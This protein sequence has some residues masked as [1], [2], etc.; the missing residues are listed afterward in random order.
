MTASGIVRLARG[1]RGRAAGSVGLAALVLACATAPASEQAAPQTAAMVLSEVR[2]AQD[3][4]TT[5]VGLYGP[6][7]AAFEDFRQDQPARIVVDLDGVAPGRVAATTPVYDGTVEEISVAAVPAGAGAQRTRVELSLA[8]AADY[9]VVAREDHLEVRVT[10]QRSAAAEPAPAEPAPTGPPA[11]RLA[12]VRGAVEGGGTV[13]RLQADGPIANAEHFPLSDPERL[14]VDLPGVANA[15]EASTKVGTSQVKRVRV[16]SHEGKVRVVIDGTGAGSLAGAQVTPTADGLAIAFGGASLAPLA[17]APA[18]PA[19]KAAAAAPAAKAQVLGVQFDAQDAQERVAVLT[20]TEAEYHIMMPDEETFLVS[21]PD[22]SIDPEAAIRIAPEKPGSVSLVTAFQQPG[23]TPEVRVVVRRA[24]GLAPKVRREG[25]ML[26]V[27]FPKSSDVAAGVP[28]L[29]QESAAVASLE[30]QTPSSAPAKAEAAALAEVTGDQA[31]G[32][33]QEGGMVHAKKYTGRRVSLDFKEVEIADVLR[34]IADVSELNIIAGDE[35]K[36][37]VTIRLVDVPWDQALDVILLTKGLGFVRVGN[38]LRIAPADVL[39][40]EEEARLQEKRA[41]EKLEDLVVKLQ[42][43]NYANVKD[44]SK[45]VQRLLTARGTVDVDART[46]TL[47]IKDINAVIDEAT[48]L[49]KAIDTQTPQVLI[50]SKI[51]EANLDFSRELGAVWAFGTQPLVDGFDESSGQRTDL[52]GNDVRLHDNPLLT[53]FTE[54]FNH[55][56]VANPITSVA[57]GLVD[58]GAFLLDDKLNVELRIEAAESNGEGKVISSPRVV[59]LD[60]RR[61]TIEQGVSIPFQTFENGDAKLEFIDAVL[62]LDVT[63]HITADR[64]I[65][66]KLEVQ[67]NAP[68]DSVQTPTGS[69]AIAKNEATTET[70]VK[71]GQTLVIGGIYVVQKADRHSGVPYFQNIPVL[72]YAF[73]NNEVRDLR[74]ELLVFVTPRI[75]VNPEVAS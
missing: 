13:V 52:G 26:F 37:E 72:G 33:L 17:Q 58:F 47:I 27:D 56:S 54:T 12:G 66:M 45:M 64:S 39:K 69:P 49:V 44:V 71:D 43:V 29:A 67:R 11:T 57:N 7:A 46:N 50:E 59:T 25:A 1:L 31:I 24:R 75:V 15:A 9:E 14:V 18:A 70:L 65:I 23:A 8:Q 51:V 30:G 32:M 20:S 35:V 19:A 60:N 36:G 21:F 62:K 16:G 68:D 40:A 48:A 63:P 38:V 61:A 5:V 3:A 53:D 41:K 55:V 74:K 4:S 2:V 28:M 22:A 42:P 10:P 6:A 73:R 34:L